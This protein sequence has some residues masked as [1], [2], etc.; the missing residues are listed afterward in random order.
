[1]ERLRQVTAVIKAIQIVL[2]SDDYVLEDGDTPYTPE[3]EVEGDAPY[4]PGEATSP[5]CSAELQRKVDQLHRMISDIEEKKQ[6]IDSIVRMSPPQV[7]TF[8]YRLYFLK[9]IVKK[10]KKINR[11]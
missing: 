10:V 5:P 6:K 1:M 2:V 4:S 9:F 3:D 7:Y 11:K 8:L